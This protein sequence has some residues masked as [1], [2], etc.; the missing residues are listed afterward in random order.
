MND[1]EKILFDQNADAGDRLSAL[2]SLGVLE[3][4]RG[5]EW[6]NNH[7]HT[8]YSF[9]PY[10]P[11]AAVCCARKAG[12]S[13]AGIMDHDSVGG[14]SEFIEAGEIVSMPVTVG[15]ECRTDVS[16]TPLE[17]KKLNNPDQ[18]SVAYVT[19]HGIPHQNID[20]CEKV[21]CFRFP[22]MTGAAA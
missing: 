5:G 13:T 18:N 2:S 15:F 19:M 21:L 17:G 12:L 6:V 7:I 22:C 4:Q 3:I 9:S 14:I 16:G 8:T 11:S 1:K 20:K 10:T